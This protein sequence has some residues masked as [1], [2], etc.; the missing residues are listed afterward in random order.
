MPDLSAEVSNDDYPLWGF[1]SIKEHKW[2][3]TR[4]RTYQEAW[5]FASRSFKHPDQVYLRKSLPID[6]AKLYDVSHP[7]DWLH[8]PPLWL[9]NLWQMDA[10]MR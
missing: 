3:T 7:F 5:I 1:I 2:V 6:S 9:Q 10:E 8:T 4:G